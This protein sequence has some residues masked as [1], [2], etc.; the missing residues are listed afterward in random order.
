M[1]YYA[2]DGGLFGV[3]FSVFGYEERAEQ[4]SL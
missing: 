2:T 4:N 3:R 1:I